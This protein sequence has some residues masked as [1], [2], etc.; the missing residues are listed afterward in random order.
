VRICGLYVGQV[1]MIIQR[2]PSESEIQNN[3]FYIPL[4]IGLKLKFLQN[5]LP[6]SAVPTDTCRICQNVSFTT[7]VQVVH[8]VT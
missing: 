4:N 8:P 3:L 2:D 5:V 7:S 6:V 1:I